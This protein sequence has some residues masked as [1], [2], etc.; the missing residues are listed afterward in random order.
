MNFDH[1]IV[2]ST[3]RETSAAFYAEV[4]DLPP[5]RIEGPFAAIDLGNDVALYV[6]GWSRHVARQHYAFLV[7]EDEFD[8]ILARVAARGDQH[9]ADP[10]GTRAGEINH[11]DGGRGA[12]FRDPDGHW[13][14]VI[15]V[16]YGGR[17]LAS[18]GA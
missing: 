5:A 3:D 2:P 14:E 16:R 15:T 7:A 10:Q 8:A 6:A 18:A 9:W 11:D 17:P 13:L 1:T 4:F 12:Y